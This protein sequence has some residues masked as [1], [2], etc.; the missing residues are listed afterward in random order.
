MTETDTLIQALKKIMKDKGVTYRQLTSVLNLSEAHIKR[1]FSDRTSFTLR[2]IEQI[3]KVLDVSFY[4][5]AT[6]SRNIT[7]VAKAPKNVRE[8]KRRCCE[9][10][11]YIAVDD[12]YNESYLYC[13]R[14][15]DKGSPWLGVA[16]GEEV[17]MHFVVCDLWSRV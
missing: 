7:T 14:T 10:C 9:N 3:T 17:G 15:A 8:I 13:S 11:K 6:G 5:L 2:R 12:S 16:H 1:L 4:E